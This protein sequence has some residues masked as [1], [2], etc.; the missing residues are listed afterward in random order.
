MPG[1]QTAFTMYPLQTRFE[2]ASEQIFDPIRRKWLQASPEEFVR[3]ALIQYLIQEIQVPRGLIS[4]E[5]GIRLPNGHPGR[6][7]LAVFR[8]HGQ[9]MLLAEC[10]APNI[11]VGHA[12]FFQAAFYNAVLKAPWVMATNVREAWLLDT[13]TG[14]IS[15]SILNLSSILGSADSN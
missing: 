6:Y 12:S 3:Q 9:I 14:K 2:G 8:P 4:V 15:N 10:K 7:D 11:P 1:P 13:S 5:Y